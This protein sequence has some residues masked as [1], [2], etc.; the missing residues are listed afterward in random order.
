MVSHVEASIFGR[1]ELRMNPHQKLKPCPQLAFRRAGRG[2]GALSSTR[3]KLL[4]LP[5]RVRHALWE[6]AS[7]IGTGKD[8]PVQLASSTRGDGT[9]S[10]GSDLIDVH[11]RSAEDQPQQPPSAC[12]EP[13]VQDGWIMPSIMEERLRSAYRNLGKRQDGSTLQ[14]GG[15]EKKGG[16]VAIAHLAIEY[17]I[18]EKAFR[19]IEGLTEVEFLNHF[20]REWEI[21]R[22]IQVQ[23]PQ[24][25]TPVT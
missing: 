24:S 5:S 19:G 21:G 13:E 6:S 1:D 18:S 25:L 11:G 23:I 3:E 16:V 2:T 20:Q 17:G 10:H 4:P 22:K 12:R 7:L 9:S 15:D 14:P 8:G